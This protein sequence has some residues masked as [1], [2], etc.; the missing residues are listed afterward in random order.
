MPCHNAE[1]YVGE[2]VESVLNQTYQNI[3]LI[4]VN[5]GST[6]RSGEVLERYK[7]RGVKVVTE[8]C[9]SASKARNR[10]VAES[11]GAYVQYLDA[12]D[13]LEKNKIEKQLSVLEK[14]PGYL[15]FGRWGRFYKSIEDVKFANDDQLQEWS[16]VGWLSFHCEKHQ[17]MHPAAWLISR[18]LMHKAG[19]WNENL[20]LND[21]GE[22]FARVVAMSKGLKCVPEAVSFYRTNRDPS[23]SKIRGYKAFQ[24]YFDSLVGTVAA[25]L[26]IENSVATRKAAADMFQRF[27]FEI[28]PSAPDLR[29]KASERVK[30]LGGSSLRPDLGPKGRVLG[31]L[32]GWRVVV[33]LARMM[34]KRILA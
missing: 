24:S 20:T 28:Y 1:R 23:L 15:A 32:L 21:D 16:A 5:D 11:R 9:G 4:V 8:R 25:L 31:A 3:E 22:Y 27:I 14:H 12:D 26:A 33:V 13:A 29:A 19:P 2:A 7:G 17:M 18:D 34:R 10:A 30:N 6:D